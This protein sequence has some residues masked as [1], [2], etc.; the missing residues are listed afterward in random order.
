MTSSLPQTWLGPCMLL[1]CL[2][3]SR[4]VT[5][6]VPE[7]CSHM[8]ASGHLQSLQQL[9]SG[10]P[11]LSLSLPAAEAEAGVREQGQREGRQGTGLSKK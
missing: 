5:E 2:L 1:V 11:S 6:E 4:S 3:V 10:Q 9:V 8:I 7:V